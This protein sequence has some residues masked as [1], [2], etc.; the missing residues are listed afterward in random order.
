MLRFSSL[1]VAIVNDEW[2]KVLNLKSFDFNSDSLLSSFLSQWIYL[3][4]HNFYT[5]RKINSQYKTFIACS[6]RCCLLFCGSQ[7]QCHRLT[8]RVEDYPREQ[9]RGWLFFFHSML[10]GASSVFS[11]HS[12]SSVVSLTAGYQ[13]WNKR[14]ENVLFFCSPPAEEIFWI[15][16]SFFIFLCMWMGEKMKK[17][18]TRIEF[19]QYYTATQRVG[20]VNLRLVWESFLFLCRSVGAGEMREAM[21]YVRTKTRSN[22]KGLQL[23]LFDM[24]CVG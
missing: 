13:I 5:P 18:K 10:Y 17:E 8:P 7:Q 1:L 4:F 9:H 19:L 20:Y 3:I 22:F 11:F 2:W 16:Q 23:V 6:F 15:S 12:F 14:A 24:E 21:R